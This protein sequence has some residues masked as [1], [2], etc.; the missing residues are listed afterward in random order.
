MNCFG[1][2]GGNGCLWILILLLILCC[3][4]TGVLNNLLDSCYLPIILAIAYCVCKN[5]GLSA[6]AAGAFASFFICFSKTSAGPRRW[7]S[8]RG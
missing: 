6:S 3:S 4:Q 1:N 7:S 5:G 2:F 8:R